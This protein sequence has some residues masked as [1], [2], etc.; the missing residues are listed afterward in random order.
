MATAAA[1]A[2][3]ITFERATPGRGTEKHPQNPIILPLSPDLPPL[4]KRSTSYPS[5]AAWDPLFCK[6]IAPI[7]DLQKPRN[8]RNNLIYEMKE[9]LWLSD[10]ARYNRPARLPHADSAAAGCLD[11]S[12]V[13]AAQQVLHVSFDGSVRMFCH[14]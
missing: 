11:C 6:P 9:I 2:A 12:A 1:A 10:T 14:V 3:A 8:Y 13:G 4:N 5:A 7:A